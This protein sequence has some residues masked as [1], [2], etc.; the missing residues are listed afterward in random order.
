[1]VTRSVQCAERIARIPELETVLTA[2]SRR[3][4]AQ[5]QVDAWNSLRG[6]ELP[7]LRVAELDSQELPGPRAG[8]PATKW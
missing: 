8:A 4:Q 2:K 3:P 5:A 7:P 1:M 6:P